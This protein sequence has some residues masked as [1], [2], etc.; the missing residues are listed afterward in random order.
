MDRPRPV[1]GVGYIELDEEHFVG[2]Q[3]PPSR[4]VGD[5]R[6]AALRCA[7]GSEGVRCHAFARG[8]RVVAPV[9]ERSFDPLGRAGERVV[10]RT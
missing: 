1:I 4:A 6:R 9:R 3:L 10:D 7:R 2:G 5:V 8:V